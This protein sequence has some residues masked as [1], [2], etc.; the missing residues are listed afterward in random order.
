M[1]CRILILFILSSLSSFGSE[2]SLFIDRPSRFVITPNLLFQNLE[3][4]VSGAHSSIVSFVP[5]PTLSAGGTLSY[6]W[7]VGSLY[8]GLYNEFGNYGK[9]TTYYDFRFNFTKRRG[10]LDLYLQWY[11]GFDVKELPISDDG[12]PVLDMYD[13]NL[14]LMNFGFNFYYSLNKNHS[15]QSSYKYNELQTKSSGAFLV[16]LSQYYTRIRYSNSIFPDDIIVD[17]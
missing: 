12:V 17:V 1:K 2:D 5:G 6:K 4:N 13:P 15:V 10:A 14:D 11:K 16:G 7:F 8:Y 9:K 3:L